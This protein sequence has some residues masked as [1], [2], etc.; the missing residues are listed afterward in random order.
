MW[1]SPQVNRP[2]TMKKEGIQTRNR[3]MSSKS[4]RNKRA[5][6]GFDELSKCMQDKTSPFGGAPSLTS[7][8]AHMGHLPPFSHSGHMLPTPTPIHPSFGHPHHSNR[9]PVWAEP[10]WGPS[11]PRIPPSVGA[12][13]SPLT[14]NGWKLLRVVPVMYSGWSGVGLNDWRLCHAWPHQWDTAESRTLWRA[15]V[16]RGLL[17]V[18][19][20]ETCRSGV[21]G[22][23]CHSF[24]LFLLSHFGTRFSL[25]LKKEAHER[26]LRR[27]AV[28]TSQPSH[29]ISKNVH[30]VQPRAFLH[31]CCG[32]ADR[33][34]SA[35][36][37]EVL[38][39]SYGVCAPLLPVRL[40]LH[41][42]QTS[43]LLTCWIV[44][45]LTCF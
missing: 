7:H 5:G 28:F 44:L 14:L 13:T 31:H 9:S 3:K 1:C 36:S 29:H 41:Y 22:D 10:H 37:L 21:N 27:T 4:K 30:P 25:T 16:T 20:S 38:V 42:P 18:G 12:T 6:D 35:G 15:N 26:F 45:P 40:R 19:P 23:A 43:A 8:M 11:S 2:L 24:C 17:V 33:L 32:Q 39:D 34:L